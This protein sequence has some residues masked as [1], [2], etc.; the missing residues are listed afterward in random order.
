MNKGP[1]AAIADLSGKLS[2]LA[3]ASRKQKTLCII[4]SLDFETRQSRQSDISDA[5][6]RTF[7]WI[8]HDHHGPFNQHVGFRNW[9]QFG[10]D[11]YWISGK[12]GSG[13]SVLMNY[14][15]NEPRTQ[16]MLQSWAGDTRL[17]VAKYFFWNAGAPMQKS[18]QGLLQSLLREIYGQC[19]ELVPVVCPFRWKRY[20]E[21]GATWTRVELS[22]AFRNLSQQRLLKL[23]FC[24]FVD[25]VDEY[26]GEDHSQIVG[27]LKDLNASPCVKVCLSSRPWNIFIAAF[28]TSTDQRLLL[29]DLME[30]T[31][32]NISKTDLKATSSSLYSSQRILAPANWL[33]RLSE[34][35]RGSSSGSELSSAIFSGV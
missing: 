9:L 16:E 32:K 31:F 23:K 13:K 22:E 11:I 4:N 17:I 15:A 29:E 27:V 26:D 28:G 1:H 20:Y 6:D 21:I 18:Q 10:N 19:P 30:T 3:E 25:G 34:M 12:A 14:V 2:S 24:F 5:Q 8:F 7:E 33:I 35:R